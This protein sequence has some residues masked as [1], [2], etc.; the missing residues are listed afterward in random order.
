[1]KILI[2]LKT[3]LSMQAHVL[4]FKKCVFLI[5]MCDCCTGLKKE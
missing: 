5:P 2:K 4:H 1:M 3:Y